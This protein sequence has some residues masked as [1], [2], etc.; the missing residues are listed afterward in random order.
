MAEALQRRSLTR[1]DLLSLCGAQDVL[2]CSNGSAQ[3]P[4]EVGGGMAPL[5]AA[6]VVALPACVLLGISEHSGDRGPVCPLY[7]V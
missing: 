4:A 5:V 2:R 3:A 7:R 6:R 1:R